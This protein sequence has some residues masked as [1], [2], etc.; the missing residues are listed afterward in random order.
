MATTLQAYATLC[1]T[2]ALHRGNLQRQL[3]QEKLAGDGYEG[4]SQYTTAAFAREVASYREWQRDGKPEK[5]EEEEEVKDM[6]D[7]VEPES[8]MAVGDLSSMLLGG[9]PPSGGAPGGGDESDA[10]PLE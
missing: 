2:Q 4:G 6:G 7:D 5:E 3:H 9:V 1:D 10:D 8:T